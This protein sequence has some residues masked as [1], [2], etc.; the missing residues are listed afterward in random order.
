MVEPRG[1]SRI[2]SGS[3][4]YLIAKLVKDRLGWVRLGKVGLG[5]VS[6]G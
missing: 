4:K 2:F 5:W 6:F 3:T 1:S